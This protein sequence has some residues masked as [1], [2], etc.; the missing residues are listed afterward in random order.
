[1]YSEK[2]PSL[3]QV[4]GASFLARRQVFKTKAKRRGQPASAEALKFQSRFLFPF[5]NPLEMQI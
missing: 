2:H 3:F 4:S 5:R 1:M